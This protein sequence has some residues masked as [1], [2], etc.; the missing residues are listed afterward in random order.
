MSKLSYLRKNLVNIPGWTTKR[1]IFVIESDDWG[2][3]SMPSK[4]VYDKLLT[5]GVPVDKGYFTKYDCLE[6]EED[7]TMLFD[8]LSSFKDFKGNHPTITANT[9]VA[10]PD[11]DKIQ[12]SNC[13]EYYYEPITE[14][15]KKYPNHSRSIEIWKE[16]MRSHLLWPQ[17]HGRE[18]L[19]PGEWLLAIN[20][21][22]KQELCAFEKH[23]LL[24]LVNPLI[25][26]RQ[27]GYLAAFDYETSE[28]LDS[29]RGVIKEGLD[30]FERIF[31]FRSTSFVA[32]TSIRS[33]KIDPFLRENGILFHQVGQQKQ[34]SYEKYRKKDRFWGQKNKYGQIYWRRNGKFEPSADWDF[35]WVDS[36]LR[37]MSIAFRWGKPI[38]LNSHRVNYIGGIVPKN[39][40][41]T[42]RFL[43]KLIQ[44]VLK[45]H[46]DIEFMSS[47]QLGELIL[48]TRKRSTNI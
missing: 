46:P 15:Y 43:K 45:Y 36:V 35:D 9:I 4:E 20:S 5:N 10:N 23:T 29:F 38:V 6:N 28:E 3:V 8:V 31:G 42:L 19:N 16:S 34:S 21:G 27:M 33:D 22:N 32:P 13:K 11:F 24:G 12:E 14:T 37:D 39:R 18:H 30:F 41:I 17:F 7:L 40:D 1:K 2:S 47:D 44:E 25:S 48:D 26:K